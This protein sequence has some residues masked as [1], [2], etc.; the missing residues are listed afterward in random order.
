LAW[1][2]AAA[3]TSPPEDAARLH[4]AEQRY[5]AVLASLPSPW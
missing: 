5:R 3:A 2:I 4:V 1:S